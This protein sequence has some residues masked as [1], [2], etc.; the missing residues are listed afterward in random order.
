MFEGWREL[1]RRL[2]CDEARQE[3]RQAQNALKP[4]ASF[5]FVTEGRGAWL[6]RAHS[7]P[8]SKAQMMN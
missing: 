8:F 6:G 7:S 1:L 5:L 4:V 3:R 2:V